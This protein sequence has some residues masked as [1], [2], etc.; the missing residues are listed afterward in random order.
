MKKPALI[1]ALALA[2]FASAADISTE[3]V[4][5]VR[6]VEANALKA[7]KRSLV[8]LM[9]SQSLDA[10]SSY[11]M[12]EL[13][14]MLADSRGAFGMRAT[15]VKFGVVGALVGVEYLIVRKHPGAARIFSKL[16]WTAAGITTG[17]AVHNF[18]IR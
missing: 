12:R 9:A 18:A 16:N 8:P 14:P 5:P 11:G 10:V 7:W 17:V 6:S 13:N 15:A 4:P 2:S 1:A 3:L